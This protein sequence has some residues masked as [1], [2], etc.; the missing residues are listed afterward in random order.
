MCVS[1]CWFVC[2]RNSVYVCAC[3]RVCTCVYLCERVRACAC[4]CACAT[5]AYAYACEC[6]CSSSCVHAYNHSPSSEYVS[7]EAYTQNSDRHCFPHLR[8]RAYES[9]NGEL[10]DPRHHG[11][12]YTPKP[13][14]AHA[15]YHTHGH[16][17]NG[18]A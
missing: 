8:T 16:N 12:R 10:E 3:V 1:L 14:R 6:S 5:C 7:Y 15:A 4:A 9:Q 13:A 17:N 11:A 18:S 2:V